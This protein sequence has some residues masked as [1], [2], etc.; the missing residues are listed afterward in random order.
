MQQPLATRFPYGINERI[1]SARIMAIPQMNEI[2]E[3]AVFLEHEVFGKTS[4]S[5]NVL[6]SEFI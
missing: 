2:T 1:R 4:P 6:E 5:P 3:N